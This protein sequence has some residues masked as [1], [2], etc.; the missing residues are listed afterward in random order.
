MCLKSGVN[1]GRLWSLRTL[2][3]TVGL[4]WVAFGD[5]N[6]PPEELAQHGW[7]EALQASVVTP[8]GLTAICNSGRLLDYVLVAR[9]ALGIV[10][11][12]TEAPDTP[13]KAHRGLKAMMV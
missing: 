9:N 10:S 6:A 1:V 4:P 7:L 5:W 2:V 12:V 13:W 11:G 8:E 3:A